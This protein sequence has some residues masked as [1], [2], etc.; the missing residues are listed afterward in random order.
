MKINSDE[1]IK[2]S[3]EGR[4]KI[5]AKTYGL[6]AHQMWNHKQSGKWII[7]HAGVQSIA[8]QENIIV[9][10]EVVA[11]SESFAV[12]KAVVTDGQ[13]TFGEASKAN[14]KMPYPFAMAEKRGFDRAVL[15]NILRHVGGYGADFYGEDE[16][17]DFKDPVA[18]SETTTTKAKTP[19][20]NDSPEAMKSRAL[21]ALEA[22]KNIK[23]I[24]NIQVKAMPLAIEG[25]WV[26]E[27]E[28]TAEIAVKRVKREEA[29]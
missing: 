27:L 24:E 1:Y 8:A 15:I 20:K 18:N 29:A 3:A 7:S 19:A 21:I 4:A 11:V 23:N 26:A 28:S 5:L 9:D 25:N 2:A 17:D 14:C 6:A 13:S 12:V 22:A 10:Y 16:A